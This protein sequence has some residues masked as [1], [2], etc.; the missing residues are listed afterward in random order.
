[1][2][3]VIYPGVFITLEGGEGSGKSV[4][5]Q[6]LARLFKR[7]AL[8]TREPGGTAVA[9]KI[10]KILLVPSSEKIAPLT[11]LLLYSAARAQH[12]QQKII[13]AL[14]KGKIVFCDRFTDAT[15]AYQ[16]YGRGLGLSLIQQC[17]QIATLGLKPD[18]TFLLDCPPEV[19]L[20]RARR[21]FQRQRGKK[22]DR[23]EREKISFHRRVRQG[24]L[25]LARAEKK[26]F[27]IVDAQQEETVV[28]KKI[29]EG[30]KAYE[31]L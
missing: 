19:G 6:R 5:C 26:R 4:L 3:G 13:P 17:N 1:M 12:L 20:K 28:F 31:I 11:E 2:K 29:V 14:K 27:Q 24:Y 16:A 25:K 9:D 21:R 7:R 30:L 15:V 23:L 18:L 22:E 10:R 8:V